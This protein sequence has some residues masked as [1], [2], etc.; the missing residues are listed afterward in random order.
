MLRNLWK[1][2]KLR[3]ALGKKENLFSH[4]RKWNLELRMMVSAKEELITSIKRQLR[5]ITINPDN[6]K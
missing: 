3:K 5:K 6:F 2:Y 1:I 4:L